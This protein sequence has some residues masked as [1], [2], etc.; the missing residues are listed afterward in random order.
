[1][2]S[3]GDR[4]LEQLP[5]RITNRDARNYYILRLSITR[6]DIS[7]RL[8]RASGNGPIAR[9]NHRAS[10]LRRAVII[11]FPVR[12]RRGRFLFHGGRLSLSLSRAQPAVKLKIRE[13]PGCRLGF[14]TH[15][16]DRKICR[17]H[18]STQTRART[19]R[20]RVSAP[21]TSDA[22]HVRI[23]FLFP[24]SATFRVARCRQIATIGNR[25]RSTVI[26][27]GDNRAPRIHASIRCF[28]PLLHSPLD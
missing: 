4:Y 27:A 19:E 14:E 20:S 12:N 3:I 7:F 16:T 9:K 21:R 2:T 18:N 23:F 15:Q 28:S 11:P 1:L 13:L 17:L 10:P 8:V 22:F 26:L 5:G 25:P 6:E 24:L